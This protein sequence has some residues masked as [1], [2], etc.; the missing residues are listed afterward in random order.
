[1]VL[2]CKYIRHFLME[3]SILAEPDAVGDQLLQE[4]VP[5]FEF[6]K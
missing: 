6:I 3:V 2:F 1:M 5:N 4:R